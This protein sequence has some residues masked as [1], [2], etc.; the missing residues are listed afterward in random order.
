MRIS[1]VQNGISKVYP[2]T[3]SRTLPGNVSLDF[4]ASSHTL[5]YD[6]CPTLYPYV[7]YSIRIRRRALYYFTNIVG[8]KYLIIP[9]SE[10]SLLMD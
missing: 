5:K 1:K 2:L 3:S 7:L 4:S 10:V 8:K 6:C 9:K